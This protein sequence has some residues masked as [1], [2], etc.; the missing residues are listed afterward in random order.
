M[1]VAEALYGFYNTEISLHFLHALVSWAAQ[2]IMLQK[3][4]SVLCVICRD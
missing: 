4:V 3:I 2:V 1:V